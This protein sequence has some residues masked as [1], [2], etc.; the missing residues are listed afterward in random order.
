VQQGVR[1]AVGK[2]D[3]YDDEVGGIEFSRGVSVRQ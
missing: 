1:F 3:E 2:A